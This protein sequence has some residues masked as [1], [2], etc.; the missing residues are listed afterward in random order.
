MK[1]KSIFKLIKQIHLKNKV[2]KN[3][4]KCIYCSST[5]HLFCKNKPQYCHGPHDNW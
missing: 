2:K 3:H 1:I 4:K 5:M